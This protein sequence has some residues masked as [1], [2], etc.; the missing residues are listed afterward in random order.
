MATGTVAP[1]CV[2]LAIMLLV[3]TVPA[4]ADVTFKKQTLSERFV[5]EGCD[6]ADF[7]KDGHVDITAGNTIWHGPDFSRQ[8]ERVRVFSAVTRMP[9]WGT[10]DVH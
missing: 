10:V 4:L 7:D 8:T 3:V 1:Q 5:A 9:W 6:L 2:I